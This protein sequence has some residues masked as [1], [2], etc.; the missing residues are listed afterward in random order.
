VH[1]ACVLLPPLVT[2]ALLAIA[3]GDLQGVQR[4]LGEKG[5]GDQDQDGNV[6]VAANQARARCGHLR[7]DPTQA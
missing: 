5:L 4:G 6:E 3:C 2:L 1:P 7:R